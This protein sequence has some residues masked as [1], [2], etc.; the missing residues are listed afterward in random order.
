MGEQ[1][2]T[3]TPPR[4]GAKIQPEVLSRFADAGVDLESMFA[5]GHLGNRMGVELI[6]A[7]SDLVVGTLPVEGN[8]QPYGLLHGGASAVL[9]EH[10]GSIGATLYAGPAKVA[11]GVELNCT[12]HRG[13]RSGIVTGTATPVHRG[14]TMAT[15]EVVI[16]D[17]QDRRVCTSRLT[18]LIRDAAPKGAGASH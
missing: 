3:Q 6:E 16:T 2:Q 18:C 7:S 5:G 14:R 15:Y 17:D 10:L 1:T 11:V 8:T 12:H 9:A 13:L 4:T